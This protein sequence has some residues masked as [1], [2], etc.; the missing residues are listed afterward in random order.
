[1]STSAKELIFSFIQSIDLFNFLL[2]NHH[3]RVAIIAWH[4]GKRMGLSNTQLNRV[5]LAAA[6]HDI[7][8]LKISERDKLIQI[9][10]ENPHPHARL[11][12]YMLES[13]D[14]FKPLA[15]ILFYHHWSYTE[16]QNYPKELGPV[17]IEAYIIHL[18]DRVDIAID[19]SKPVL[20]Q[21][22]KVRAEIEKRKDTL[23][24]PEVYDAFLTA[25]D[26]DRFW[27]DIDNTSM[28]EVLSK[29]DDDMLTFEM[30]T[31]MLEQ[32]AFTISKIIDCRSKFTSAHSFGVS[33]TAY[34]LAQLSGKDET[35]CRKIRIAGLL[36]DIGKIGIST[37]V[38]EK[39]GPLTSEERKHIQEHA[40][41]T[42]KILHIPKELNE[43]AEWA[44][45][46]HENHTGRGYPDNYATE[47][48][49]VE[50]DILAYADVFTALAEER[51]YRS[52]MS[53]DGII[54]TLRTEFISQH[55]Q[56]VFDVIDVHQDEVYEACISALETGHRRYNRYIELSDQYE[57]EFKGSIVK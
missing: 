17:P 52:G 26:P 10:I 51:P 2:K 16:D 42:N 57:K 40:Y 7:G 5:V 12:A 33:E 50:M 8:A 37:E 44:A 24:H 54:H 38:L 4:I 29:I 31:E 19:K 25:S 43:I 28:R 41:Y 45:H 18:A 11:G 36:H 49:T 56:Q 13:F 39:E 27:L 53:L 6:L 47:S 3:R 9:D 55:G 21:T 35:T 48:I 34:K 20:L 30:N 32:L 1:M 14:P 46:H 22:V 23:F 15:T